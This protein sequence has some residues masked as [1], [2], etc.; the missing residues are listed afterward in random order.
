[1]ELILWVLHGDLL[2]V[3]GPL[4][5]DGQTEEAQAEARDRIEGITFQCQATARLDYLRQELDDV[6]EDIVLLSFRDALI[7]EEFER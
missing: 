7:E 2:V 5:I 3:V 1:M 6:D 4:G